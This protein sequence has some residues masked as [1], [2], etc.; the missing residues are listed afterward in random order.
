MGSHIKHPNHHHYWI[1]NEELYETYTTIRGMRFNF[2]KE[3]PGE[4]D[5][6]NY[7]PNEDDTI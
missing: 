4:P 2:V 1:E 6:D 3:V 5:N 7:N